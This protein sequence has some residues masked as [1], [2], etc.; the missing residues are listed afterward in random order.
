MEL[1]WPMY[2]IK[3]CL[4]L[5]LLSLEFT[6]VRPVLAIFGWVQA[7]FSESS[8]GVTPFMRGARLLA[9]IGSYSSEGGD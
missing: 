3:D 5:P 2:V 4:P 6:A 1:K 9:C 8:R 7:E